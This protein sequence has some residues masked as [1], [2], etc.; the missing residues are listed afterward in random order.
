MTPKEPCFDT[1]VKADQ[2][3]DSTGERGRDGE[4]RGR[5]KEV[6]EYVAPAVSLE[7]V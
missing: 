3:K 5:E 2:Q 4:M 1:P 7:K 6:K